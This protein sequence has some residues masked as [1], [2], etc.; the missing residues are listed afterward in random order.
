M[1]IENRGIQGAGPNLNAH[2]NTTQREYDE[3]RRMIE[4]HAAQIEV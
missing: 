1:A 4:A 2:F 3:C